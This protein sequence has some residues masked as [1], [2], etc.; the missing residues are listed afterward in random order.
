MLIPYPLDDAFAGVELLLRVDATELAGTALEAIAD[1]RRGKTY[2]ARPA[3]EKL[4]LDYPTHD[5]WS[6]LLAECLRRM[7][8]TDNARLVLAPLL[9]R[10]PVS[11][12]AALLAAALSRD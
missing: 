10:V 8:E 9:E 3:L 12:P 11:A 7:G 1:L 2:L 5:E 6:I 4:H